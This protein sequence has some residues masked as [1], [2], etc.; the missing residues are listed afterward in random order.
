MPGDL[1][2]PPHDIVNPP[3]LLPPVGFS[4]AVV[5]SPGR[6]VHLGGQSGHRGDGSLP[7]GMVAQFEQ[8]V[9]NLV[10]TLDAA[11]AHP[12]HL[13]SLHVYVTDAAE[14]RANLG[15]LGA[16]YRRHVGRHYPA[17]A[18]FEVTALFDADALVELVAVA[19]VPDRG[20]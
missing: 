12:D 4:H 18:L 15:R 2:G 14:Y 19:V 11:G 16:V 3:E 20:R 7:G 6:T 9:A 8:A 17:M 13:V 1:G 10:T 5:S